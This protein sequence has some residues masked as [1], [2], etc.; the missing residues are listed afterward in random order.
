MLT[1]R[2]LHPGDVSA[3]VALQEIVRR[4]LRDPGLYQCEDEAYFA[5]IIAGSG[6][7]FAAFDGETMA[8]YGIIA[9]PGVHPGN[10][11]HD[12]PALKIDPTEVAHLDG[13]AVHPA[14]R[15]LA[16]QHRLSVL[17]I[18]YGA[19]R[20]ARHFL[21][22]V[23]PA[24]LPSLRNH[25]NGGG[26]RALALKQKYGGLWR[27]ILHRALDAEEPTSAGPRENCRLD[28]LETHQR[29]LAA[30]YAGIRLV[31]RDGLWHLAYEKSAPGVAGLSARQ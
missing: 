7:G 2:Q 13:S 8:G 14:Y 21:L 15:G 11:C 23:S 5:R 19:T 28:D 31:N 9:F 16:I 26:F 3:L 22:T 24:N 18:A 12:L 25:L 17:R 30:G 4:G 20:G 29:L 10:L 27:L 6:A 1:F